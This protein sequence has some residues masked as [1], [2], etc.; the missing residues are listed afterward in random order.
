MRKL[1]VTVQF[2]LTNK[3]VVNC[4]KLNFD[5]DK[6]DNNGVWEMTYTTKGNKNSTEETAI[7]GIKRELNLHK[8]L[9]NGYKIL[10]AREVIANADDYFDN[11]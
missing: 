6:I 8:P 11:L 9:K 2:D 4:L 1:M 5:Y 3:A 10:G 7:K